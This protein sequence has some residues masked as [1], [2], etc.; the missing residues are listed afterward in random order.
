[1]SLRRLIKQLFSSRAEHRSESEEQRYD[2]VRIVKVAD[3]TVIEGHDAVKAHFER[4]SKM[5]EEHGSSII[6]QVFRL[7]LQASSLEE[8]Q[9]EQLAEIKVDGEFVAGSDTVA[10]VKGKLR[11]ILEEKARAWQAQGEQP[12]LQIEQEDHITLFF[13]G[14]PMQDD[15][16][17]YADH[18]MLLPAWVQ[19]HLHSCEFGQVAKRAAELRNVARR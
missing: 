7:N 18:F 2:N 14:H 3:G 12:D 13:N 8:F 9:S 5:Q 15:R 11:P 1:M 16:L 6:F 19:V 10:A 17:F 4:E